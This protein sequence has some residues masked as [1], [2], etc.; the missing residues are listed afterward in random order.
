MLHESVKGTRLVLFFLIVVVSTIF[1]CVR[2]SGEDIKFTDLHGDYMGQKP[3]GLKPEIFAPGVV[4]TEKRELNSVFTPDG[5][6]FF[7]SYSKPDGEYTIMVMRRINN[8]W[9]LPQVAAFSK[10]FSNVDMCVSYDGKKLFFGSNR[11]LSEKNTV[12]DGFDIWMVKKEG[13]EWGKPINLGPEVNAGRHQIY[14]SVARNETLYF[15]S[16]REGNVGGSDIY[17]SEYGSG[18]YKKPKNLGRA[19]NTEANEGDVCVAPDE[20]FLI[21]SS[22][23]RPDSYG[24]GDLYISIRQKD[25]SWSYAENMGE[26]INSSETEYCPMLSPDGKYLFFTSRKSG[27]G[28]IYWVDARSIQNLRQKK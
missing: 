17:R 9:T 4:S 27:N 5:N 2:S 25:G 6:E 23:G 11:P 26:T 28:D 15:Q 24:K 16:R 8:R 21:V 1:L 7:F 19:I 12:K 18:Q 20:S 3:P 13:Q 10:V 14:P 22:S